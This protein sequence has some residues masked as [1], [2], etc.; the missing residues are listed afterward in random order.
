MQDVKPIEQWLADYHTDGV[1]LSVKELVQYRHHVKQLDLTPKRTPQARLAG[2]YVTRLKGRGMEFDESRHYQPGDD[3][4]AID[5]RVT[6]RTGKT[7]TKIFREERERPVYIM[8]DLSANMQFGSQFSFKAVQAAHFSALVGWSAVSRG[9]KVG[10]LAFNQYQHIENKPKGRQTAVLSQIHQLVSL[11]QQAV[12][13]A[14]PNG[15]S[16]IHNGKAFVDNCARLFRLAKPGSLVWIVSDF[17]HLDQKS[18]RTLSDINRHCE[19][20]A[21]VVS[22]PL[23]LSLPE[24]NTRQSLTVTDGQ[25]RQSILLGDSHHN[26]NYADL[27]RQRMLVLCQQLE[28]LNVVSHAIDA[29]T[30]L[31]HQSFSPLH[32]RQFEA[33]Q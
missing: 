4:R 16:A 13:D 31:L 12:A 20:R 9:D 24:L 21:A 17:S 14:S 23:E 7:H 33:Y 8:T 11:Q 5:W 18:L 1:H 3:I 10:S 26:T 29:G 19:V 28:K 25:Q 15:D 27:A 30:P 32:S 22:D 2:T 6:A